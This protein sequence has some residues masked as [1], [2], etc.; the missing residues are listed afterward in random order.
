MFDADQ[1]ETRYAKSGELNIAY[2]LFGKGDVNVVVLIFST[3][4]DLVAGSG[5]AFAD[6]GRR[7]APCVVRACRAPTG[8]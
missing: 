7:L 5:I 6:L 2:Q 3:V 4:K 1:I 8:R